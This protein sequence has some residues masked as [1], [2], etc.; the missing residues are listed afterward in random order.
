M[1]RHAVRAIQFAEPCWQREVQRAPWNEDPFHVLEGFSDL[2]HDDVDSCSGSRDR[3]LGDVAADSSVRAGVACAS[4]K[5][6]R[7]RSS[8]SDARTLKVIQYSLLKAV[9][10]VNN[11]H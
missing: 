8:V 2:A 11:C 9:V 5:H 4:R 10:M 7:V 1:T 6:D 3:I